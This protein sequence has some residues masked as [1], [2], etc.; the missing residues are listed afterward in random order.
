[1]GSRGSHRDTIFPG[2]LGLNQPVEKV[3]LPATTQRDRKI[4]IA[5]LAGPE[6]TPYGNDCKREVDVHESILEKPVQWEAEADGQ[7]PQTVPRR[8]PAR[9]L[10]VGARAVKTIP[11]SSVS[12]WKS[13]DRLFKLKFGQMDYVTVAEKKTGV[14]KGSPLV[15]I[16]RLIEPDI[17]GQILSIQRIQHPHF[18]TSRE[19]LSLEGNYFVAFEFMPLSLSELA[20]CPLL[21]ELRLASILG[22]VS[23]CLLYWSTPLT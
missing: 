9:E 14:K 19:M 10:T 23:F 16:K 1:M 2:S 6:P 20:A 15:M 21:N 7:G 5:G 8:H 3:A 13:F 11:E 4:P 18:L 12:S 22:Q 17:N